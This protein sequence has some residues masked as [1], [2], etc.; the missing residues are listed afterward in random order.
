MKKWQ[1]VSGYL[2]LAYALGLIYQSWDLS[3]G[4]PGQPGPGFLGFFLG[5]GMAILSV[6]LIFVNRGPDPPPGDPRRKPFWGPKA[7]L[8]P[9]IAILGLA[10]FVSLMPVLGTV[11]TMILFFFLW[12]KVLEKQSWLLAVMLATIGTASFY[13][14]FGVLLRIQLPKGIFG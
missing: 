4:P 2:I 11:L 10:A 1:K 7:W 9:M 8:K 13:L 6:C 12:I 3:L 5:I 14:V